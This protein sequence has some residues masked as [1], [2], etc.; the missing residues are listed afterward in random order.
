MGLRRRKAGLDAIAKVSCLT[1]R[2]TNLAIRT[3][4]GDEPRPSRA[5]GHSRPKD[6][7]GTAE[8]APRFPQTLG[9]ALRVLRQDPRARATRKT[10]QTK[11]N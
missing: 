2:R 10:D 1:S 5:T 8:N 11:G 7:A 6:P 4:A 3:A 9:K